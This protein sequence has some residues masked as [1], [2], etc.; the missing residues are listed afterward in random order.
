MKLILFYLITMK[1][2]LISTIVYLAYGHEGDDFIK[3]KHDLEF[4]LGVVNS[5]HF[6]FQA[7]VPY[8]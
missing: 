4:S 5:T 2:V 6:Y 1:F 7:E 3:I 8:N